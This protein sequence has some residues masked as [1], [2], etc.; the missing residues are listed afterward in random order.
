MIKY[1]HLFAFAVL[2]LNASN[3]FSQTG[4]GGIG[5]TARS[6]D[7]V[8]WLSPDQSG[9]TNESWKD[10]SGKG[11]HFSAEIGALLRANAING[12]AAYE[13]NGVSNYFEKSFERDL[14]PEEFSIFSATKV[15]SSKTFKV[16]LSSRDEYNLW[17]W[18]L[19]FY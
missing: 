19:V 7:L 16:V 6:S 8:L 4:P 9:N 2:Y 3:L 1:L 17:W 14:N 12:Y 15:L 10:Q 18:P 5:S 11:Y 13:F